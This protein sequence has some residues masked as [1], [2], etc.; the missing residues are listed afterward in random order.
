MNLLYIG[1]TYEFIYTE[2]VPSSEK[3]MYVEF[4]KEGIVTKSLLYL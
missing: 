3:E 1:I 4:S 2:N